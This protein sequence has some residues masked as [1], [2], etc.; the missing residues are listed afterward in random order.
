MIKPQT[1][2]KLLKSVE[3]NIWL[4]RRLTYLSLLDRDVESQ[5]SSLESSTNQVPNLEKNIPSS[6]SGFPRQD[7]FSSSVT[8][9]LRTEEVT[10][11]SQ[12][13]RLNFSQQKTSTVDDS[14]DDQP[15]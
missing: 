7:T 4:R 11:S 15:I 3:K 9:T 8:S 2:V 12:K 5:S 6:A 14:K 1:F 10:S 13:L